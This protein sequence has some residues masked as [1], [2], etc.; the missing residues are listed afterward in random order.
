MD[1]LYAVLVVLNVIAVGAYLLYVIKSYT[2]YWMHEI[3]EWGKTKPLI[4]G[5]SWMKAFHVP[6]RQVLTCNG[7]TILS[8]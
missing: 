5:N 1:A 3:F 7:H 2:P 6:N 8:K 4:A